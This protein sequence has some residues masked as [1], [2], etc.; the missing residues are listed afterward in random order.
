[1]KIA[2]VNYERLYVTESPT[3]QPQ[4]ERH[5]LVVWS[6]GAS[7]VVTADGMGDIWE[8]HANYDVDCDRPE[9]VWAFTSQ[10]PRK[11]GFTY[12]GTEGGYPMT[13]DVTMRWTEQGPTGKPSKYRNRSAGFSYTVK[14]S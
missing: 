2:G 5:F 8:T 6:D 9:H 7:A 11:V 12:A 4:I 14:E 1:M 3:D 10:G 13:V